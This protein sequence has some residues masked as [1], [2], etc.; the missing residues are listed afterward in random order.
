[1][2]APAG[3]AEA[4]AAIALPAATAAAPMTFGASDALPARVAT[5][6]RNKRRP[7]NSPS[8]VEFVLMAPS[9]R[10]C[11]GQ[12]TG[13]GRLAT[14][15]TR[16]CP[17]SDQM[18]DHAHAAPASSVEGSQRG[19]L[20]RAPR[21]LDHD[22]ESTVARVTGS[23]EPAV[24]SASWLTLPKHVDDS[25]PAEPW[26]RSGPLAS[27]SLVTPTTSSNETA[28]APPPAAQFHTPCPGFRFDLD[29]LVAWARSVGVA[30]DRQSPRPRRQPVGVEAA[31]P[32][33]PG[34]AGA[35]PS[36]GRGWPLVA[37]VARS[38]PPCNSPSNSSCSSRASLSIRRPLRPVRTIAIR[39]WD[40]RS[41]SGDTSGAFFPQE[42]ESRAEIPARRSST[43][44]VH[45]EF[46][47]WTGKLDQCSSGE[48]SWRQGASRRTPGSSGSRLRRRCSRGWTRGPPAAS[49]KGLGRWLGATKN[50]LKEAL[51][52]VGVYAEADD[53]PR[54][55]S[56]SS[57][58]PN[59][60][61]LS[62]AERPHESPCFRIRACH[63]NTSVSW[64][65]NARRAGDSRSYAE[66]SEKIGG[67]AHHRPSTSN[68]RVAGSAP[69]RR[70]WK[71]ETYDCESGVGP[72]V[73]PAVMPV[74][75]WATSLRSA[76]L[77]VGTWRP[78]SA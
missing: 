47:I 9:S 33:G 29:L 21:S 60:L 44:S 70:P 78:E 57:R 73:M 61:A 14:R 26:H 7:V 68:P 8:S 35:S 42:R 65:I 31:R 46:P 71:S 67:T 37:G 51:R 20:R 5:C 63:E 74:S 17:W 48:M 75:F 18:S 72:A 45:P 55:T 12:R 34:L 69:A 53:P 52:Q 22:D 39:R 41:A 30:F 6:L 13:G 23:I 40:G 49:R 32:A 24:R 66:V 1:M 28:P 15:F 19:C 77:T 4:G 76:G 36:I 58:W 27:E 54:E 16:A 50:L 56:G 59:S 64:A 3:C 11:C 43:S 62:C 2:G 25:Q 38:R 10:S